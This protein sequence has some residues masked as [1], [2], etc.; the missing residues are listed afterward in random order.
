[1][2][3]VDVTESWAFYLKI[4]IQFVCL[5]TIPSGPSSAS[6]VGLLCCV[7]ICYD[8]APL[9]RISP[10]DL[11]VS[12]FCMQQIAHFSRLFEQ[13][14]FDAKSTN[15]V[16]VVSSNY[17]Y[18]HRL[19]KA[20]IFSKLANS[21]SLADEVWFSK[22]FQNVFLCSFVYWYRPYMRCWYPFHTC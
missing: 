21:F 20:A 8:Q 13:R 16:A 2:R 9:K 5:K 17:N 4:C 18:Y 12:G 6:S 11:T 3:R 22:L 7:L 14:H 15:Y 19:G 1:M 10:L